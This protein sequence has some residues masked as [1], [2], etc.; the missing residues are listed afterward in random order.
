MTLAML[1]VWVI[2]IVNWREY[3]TN[4]CTSPRLIWPLATWMPPMTQI[5]DVVEVGDELHR[6]LDDP[7]QELGPIAGL[8]EALVL[9]V[10]LLDR[11]LLA[12]ERLDDAVPGVHLLDV[13]VERP[14]L[15]PLAGELLRRA[16]GDED[17]DD[18]RQRARSAAR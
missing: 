4:A 16:L 10:E 8:E 17:R 5:S 1:A 9:D 6:R 14:G 11:L 12:T 3:W 18:D 15:L 7:G 2:G 13:A